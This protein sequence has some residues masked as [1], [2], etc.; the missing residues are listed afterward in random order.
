MATAVPMGL[1]TCLDTELSARSAWL[2]N[3]DSLDFVN[4]PAKNGPYQYQTP[5]ILKQPNIGL[6]ALKPTPRN[7]IFLEHENRLCEMLS[8]LE[9]NQSMETTEAREDMEDRVMQ[10]LLRINRLKELEW[11]GQRSKRGIKGA[12]VN[13]GIVVSFL[14]FEITADDRLRLR[15]PFHTKTSQQYNYPCH[16]CDNASYVYLISPSASWRNS[17][18]GRHEEYPKE[19]IV[20]FPVGQ[21]SPKGP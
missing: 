10:E 11:S 15:E 13:T 5:D 18:A 19:S 4:N 9:S 1:L 17:T 7:H 8:I 16:L 2:P 20:A 3:V 21:R 6:Y 12:V 14:D